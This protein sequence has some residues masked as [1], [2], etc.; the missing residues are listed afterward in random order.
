MYI[1]SLGIHYENK[2]ILWNISFFYGKIYSFQEL[3]AYL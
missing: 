1:V 2:F 3:N